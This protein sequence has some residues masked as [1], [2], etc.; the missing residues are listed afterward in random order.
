MTNA[1]NF[2]YTNVMMNLFLQQSTNEGAGMNFGAMG[3][4]Q[5]YWEVLQ[6]PILDGLYWEKW[7]NGANASQQ[8][9]IYFEN[10][11]LGVPRLRQLRVKKGSCKVHSLF[12]NAIPDCYD[13][14]SYFSEDQS[15]IGPYAQ[16][17]SANMN[18]TA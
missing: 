16:N 13:S 4:M 14:Y 6:G 9:Y 12:R 17:P 18:D 5:D 3:S 11:I 7:Y 8:G 1:I 15:P 2:Y 10:K